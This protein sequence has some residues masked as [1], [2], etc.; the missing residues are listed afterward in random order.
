M[1]T[2]AKWGQEPK[3]CA[4]A[5][6]FRVNAYL[7]GRKDSSPSLTMPVAMANFL[8]GSAGTL[9]G[10]QPT[11]LH[12]APRTRTGPAAGEG[13]GDLVGGVEDAL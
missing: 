3:G 13:S 5:L 12:F 1:L 2:G 7:E 4:P 9:R 8:A 6:A 10:E 11:R